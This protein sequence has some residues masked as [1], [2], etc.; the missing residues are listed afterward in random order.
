VIN[1]KHSEL[2]G[3]INESDELPICWQ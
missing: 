1:G 2:V 3:L